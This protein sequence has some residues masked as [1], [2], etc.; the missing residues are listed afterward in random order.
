MKKLLFI[1]LFIVTVLAYGQE[2]NALVIENSNDA[3]F[4]E[5]IQYVQDI[6][7]K[8]ANIRNNWVSIE[9]LYF[10]INFGIGARYERMLSPKFSLGANVFIYDFIIFWLHFGINPFFRYYPWGKTFF[11]SAAL[12]IQ[13]RTNGWRAYLEDHRLL[14]F[15]TGITPEVGWKIDIGKAGSF[16]IQPSIAYPI[17]FERGIS[18]DNENGAY[19]KT[20]FKLTGTLP[21][22]RFGVGY[23]F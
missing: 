16:F 9:L 1:P 12:N 8:T 6:P 22:L 19:K 13:W 15:G 7:E 11:V 17:I 10:Y 5:T 14:V 23:A 20:N 2:E 21:V 3:N 4:D 18:I